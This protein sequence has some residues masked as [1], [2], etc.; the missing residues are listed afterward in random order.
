MSCVLQ[1]KENMYSSVCM[2]DGQKEWVLFFLAWPGTDVFMMAT[3]SEGHGV[4]LSMEHR[5]C[6]TKHSNKSSL[7]LIRQIVQRCIFG[8]GRVHD[9]GS[10]NNMAKQR[11]G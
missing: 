5:L 1:K 6:K 3:I 10:S 4:H 2:F 7:H 11:H 9:E 8:P